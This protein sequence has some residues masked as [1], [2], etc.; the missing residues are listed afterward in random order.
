MHLYTSYTSDV[1]VSVSSTLCSVLCSVRISV[2][3]SVAVVTISEEDTA[4]R[5]EHADVEH[6]ER[7]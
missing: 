7:C 5:V 6:S 1:I 2:R 4:A 3:T